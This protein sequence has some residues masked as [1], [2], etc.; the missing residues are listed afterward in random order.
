MMRLLL[1]TT[2]AMSQ[3]GGYEISEN[4]HVLEDGLQIA[5]SRGS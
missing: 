5:K 3:A 1:S 4:G 2:P